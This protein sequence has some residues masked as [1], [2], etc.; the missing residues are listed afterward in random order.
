MQTAK[1]KNEPNVTVL[2]YIV[3][4]FTI[5]SIIAFTLFEEI[6][7]FISFNLIFIFSSIDLILVFC[8]IVILPLALY[9]LFLFAR[10][11]KYFWIK[12]EFSK[13][14][15]II[16]TVKNYF[17]II[18]TS[19]I[20]S[21]YI[22]KKS[23]WSIFPLLITTVIVGIIGY[24]FLEFE[25]MQKRQ[26]ERLDD[27]LKGQKAESFPII[28]NVKLIA[29]ATIIMLYF[30]MNDFRSFA[31]T[32]Y[33]FGSDF[34]AFRVIFWV[35]IACSFF[36]F[37]L[38]YLVEVLYLAS[39]RDKTKFYKILWIVTIFLLFYLIT[40]LTIFNWVESLDEP[41][42]TLISFVVSSLGG[43]AQRNGKKVVN[44]LT[45]KRSVTLGE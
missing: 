26:E 21:S 38:T 15:A 18:G 22:L 39:K 16:E 44:F 32:F 34:F 2:D 31:N 20:S 35:L 42:R 11:V 8:L 25:K 23:I 41:S 6:K 33:L 24:F 3:P 13:T 36:W 10:V 45:K 27:I 29:F 40:K 17:L 12:Y 28:E 4:S 37:F 14:W 30:G 19:L 9:Y 5:I 1:I 43:A 7:S